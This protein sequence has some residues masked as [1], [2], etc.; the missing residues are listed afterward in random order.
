MASKRRRLGGLFR[1]H[2]GSPQ[3]REEEGSTQDPESNKKS[4]ENLATRAGARN[5]GIEILY[6]NERHASGAVVD[7]VFVHSL[8]GAAFD[9][10]FDKKRKYTGQASCFQKTY[11]TLEF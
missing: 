3:P 7:I 4:S 10:W 9:T 8:T 1:S 2:W 5:C 11:L 6:D